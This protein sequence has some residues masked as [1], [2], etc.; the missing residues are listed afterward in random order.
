MQA[1]VLG[2]GV[3]VAL[4]AGFGIHCGDDAAGACLAGDEGCPCDA[5][6]CAPGLTCLS[7][8]C[9]S[10]PDAGATEVEPTGG[11]AGA[12]AGT[13]EAPT[14]GAASTTG[15]APPSACPECEIPAWVLLTPETQTGVYGAIFG[16]AWWSVCD[17]GVLTSVTLYWHIDHWVAIDGDCG[18]LSVVDDGGEVAVV[19]EPGPKLRRW[20]VEDIGEPQTA[21]CPKDHVMVGFSGTYSTWLN[22]LVLSCAPLVVEPV[23]GEYTIRPGEPVALPMLGIPDGLEIEAQEC[24]KERVFSGFVAAIQWDLYGFGA[25]CVSMDLQY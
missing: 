23:D 21:T 16:T 6:T 2:L 14:T 25:T 4:V 10:V 11:S 19:V 8:R 1:R 20:G 22:S 7:D 12:T 24:H 18:L 9:V 17:L 5:G 13:M 3:G 15:E